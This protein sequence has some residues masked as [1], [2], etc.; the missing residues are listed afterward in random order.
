M[1]LL[2]RVI[3][4]AFGLALLP[5]AA[6]GQTENISTDLFGLPDD[7]QRHRVIVFFDIPPLSFDANGD[8]A[9]SDAIALMDG[10]RDNIIGRA[11]GISAATLAANPPSGNQPSAGP[12]IR[13]FRHGRHVSVGR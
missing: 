2:I 10:Q 12:R 1:S 13:L 3:L 4:L 5:T 9:S 8:P 6:I 11:L 7:G